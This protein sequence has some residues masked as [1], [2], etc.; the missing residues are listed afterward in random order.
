MAQRDLSNFQTVGQVVPKVT[1][2]IGQVLGAVAGDIMKSNQEAKIN[3]NLSKAQIDL[4]SLD[5]QFKI[6]YEGDP[7]NAEGL[8]QY[9]EKR[10]EVFDTYGAEISPVYRK[11]WNENTLKISSQND[12]TIQAWGIDQSKK[13]TVSSI[14]T[15]L[16]NNL[17]AAM[18]NG[19][20]FAN[21]G[22]TEMGAYLD[23]EN[24][25][26]Q[27]QAFGER[28]LGSETTAELLGN[29]KS[30]Y[31][32]TFLSGVAD[33]N[34]NKALQLMQDPNMANDFGDADTYM[35]MKNSIERK[36]K[37]FNKMTVQRD[38]YSSIM[39]GNE[40][41]ASSMQKPMGYA[42]LQTQIEQKKVSP[43]TGAYL[44]KINGFLDQT[45]GKKTSPEDKMAIK[46][47]I[48][49][50]VHR[51]TS[52]NEDG[53]PRD[54][55]AEEF[56]AFQ[57]TVYRAAR[58]GAI[59]P[60]E[61]E[62]FVSDLVQPLADSKVKQFEHPSSWSSPTTWFDDSL[63]FDKVNSMFDDQIA[64]P[65][66]DDPSN[67]TKRTLNKKNSMV[68]ALNKVKMADY[69]YGA[70][71]EQAN[72]YGV[73]SVADIRSLN[74]MQQNKIKSEAFNMAKKNFMLDSHPILSTLNDL[75]NQVLDGGTLTQGMAGERNVKPD[76]IAKPAFDVK[77]GSDGNLYRV[78]P[79]G[80]QE[81][82]GKAPE[83]MSF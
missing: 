38:G 42:D 77:L 20:N 11:Y 58:V 6:D 47:E 41:V 2:P 46:M 25:I 13:N 39:A 33:V 19:Q 51:V 31:L 80:T 5:N 24:S 74:K 48:Y 36:A 23:F 66:D 49:D 61:A 55:S 26:N 64:L 73:K 54:I 76:A 27:V 32:K 10:K 81:N 82:A 7:T 1:D 60:K 68:N 35:R 15:S 16:Q 8:K 52:P 22:Q 17:T 56:G 37:S 40:L 78:Y 21:S 79:D 57:D 75:P 14:N 34:P 45:D 59:T 3:E 29:Y 12:L 9:Q 44:M 28:N 43:E 18:I 69:Y 72:S 65:I 53:E 83:G 63:G 50:K 30:D 62:G 70:L 67:E 4:Q 71:K